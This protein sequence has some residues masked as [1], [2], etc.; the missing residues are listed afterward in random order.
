MTYGFL[1]LPEQVGHAGLQLLSK[2]GVVEHLLDARLR[3]RDSHAAIADGGSA[4]TRCV[5]SL[6]RV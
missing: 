4:G 5:R 1:Q 6:L 3:V 2:L